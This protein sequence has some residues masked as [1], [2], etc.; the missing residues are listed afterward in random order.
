MKYYLIPATDADMLGL[1]ECRRGNQE[2]GYVVTTGDLCTAPADMRD[3]A[4]EMTEAEA[5]DYI[6]KNNL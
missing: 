3:S 2:S 5:V 1:T 4:T 6:M